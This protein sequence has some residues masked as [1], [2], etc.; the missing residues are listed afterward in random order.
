MKT[1]ATNHTGR[2]AGLTLALLLSS[3]GILRA[4]DQPQGVPRKMA[5]TGNFDWSIVPPNL[6]PFITP[7]TDGDLYLRHLPL[8]GNFTLAGKGVALDAKIHVDLNGELDGTGTGVVWGTTVI[9]ATIGGAKTIIFQGSGSADTVGL[10]SVGTMTLS[11]RGPF[12]DSKLEFTFEE[13]GP[14]D[15]NTYNF[16]G[17]LT[18]APRR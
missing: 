17:S 14:G 18:P 3:S 11:G 10:V 12:A 1:T 13:I 6:G 16:Q 2:L 4:E 5:V 7:G 9:T 8:V 15:S